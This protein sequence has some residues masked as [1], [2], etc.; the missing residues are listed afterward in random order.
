[1]SAIVQRHLDAI[2]ASMALLNAQL[3]ALRHELAS[4]APV[5]AAKEEKPERPERCTGI[6]DYDCAL[7]DPDARRKRGT[8]GNPGAWMCAGCRFE[9]GTTP[10]S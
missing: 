2:G 10:S 1:M 9:G 8:L 4:P 6:E 3:E 5:P 7:R